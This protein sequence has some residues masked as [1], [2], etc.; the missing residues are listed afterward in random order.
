MNRLALGVDFAVNVAFVGGAVRKNTDVVALKMRG[1]D[2][3][4][5]KDH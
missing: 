4:A 1:Y 3:E 2:R 5:R